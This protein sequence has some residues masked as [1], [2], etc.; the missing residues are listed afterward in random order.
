[1]HEQET[2]HDFGPIHFCFSLLFCPCDAYRY[3]PYSFCVQ[4]LTEGGGAP[5]QSVKEAPKRV[6]PHNQAVAAF[7]LQW[8]D[9]NTN[10]ASGQKR[11]ALVF[12]GVLKTPMKV[13]GKDAPDKFL[14]GLSELERAVQKD[15]QEVA[16]FR[17][18]K[19]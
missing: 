4:N 18:A 17:K 7:R 9:L 6:A 13:A 15:V 12:R 19:V 1:M 16:S 11:W 5:C 8:Q 14:P 10:G 3:H 2:D